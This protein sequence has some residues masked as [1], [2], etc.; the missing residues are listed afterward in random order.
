MTTWWVRD[1][2]I[3]LEE[4]LFF[5]LLLFIFLLGGHSSAAGWQE[6]A[7]QPALVWEAGGRRRREIEDVRENA[8]QPFDM[9]PTIGRKKT[10][11]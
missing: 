4:R 1:V 3:L 10:L 6:H 11:L 9:N 5:S 8:R 2:S 7:V